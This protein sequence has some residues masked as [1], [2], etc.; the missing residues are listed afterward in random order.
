MKPT[1]VPM[2]ATQAGFIRSFVEI[3]EIYHTVCNISKLHTRP[4]KSRNFTGITIPSATPAP[5][6]V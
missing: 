4:E 6:N 2:S 5:A 3:F 1:H